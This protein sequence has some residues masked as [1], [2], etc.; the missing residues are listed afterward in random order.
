VTIFNKIHYSLMVK[1]CYPNAQSPTWSPPLV[2]SPRTFC[3]THLQPLSVS[4]GRLLH[5]NLRIWHAVVTPDPL[6][7]TWGYDTLW[8]QRI[9]W[10]QPEDMTR[11]GDS[12]FAGG[13]LR[14]WH[15]VV[16][17]DPLA[18][19]W[20]YDT[21][22]WQRIRWPQPEDMTRC[23]DT[24]SALFYGKVLTSHADP[25]LW[26]HCLSFLWGCLFN[27]LQMS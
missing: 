19:T 2:G 27:I 18:S 16:T 15:A 21:L 23:G 7:A 8:W 14:I 20:G 3:K 12:G 5:S 1:D 25:T 11:C 10:P 17:A 9:R 4:V 26:N 24:G 6:A 22:W 13:N